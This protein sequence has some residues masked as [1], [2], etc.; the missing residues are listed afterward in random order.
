MVRGFTS[1]ALVSLAAGLSGTAARADVEAPV[2]SVPAASRPALGPADN[3]PDGS[4]FRPELPRGTPAEQTLRDP[5]APITTLSS[6]IERAYWANPQLLAERARARSLDYRIPQARGQYGPQIEYSAS[7]GYQRN[8]Y[9]QPIGPWISRS[10]WTSAAS[11]VLRQPLFTFGRLRASE[12]GARAT[13]AFGQASLR[14]TEQQTMFAAINAYALLM[15]DRIGVRI[16]SDNVELLATHARDTQTRLDA[17]ESTA[18]DVQQVVARLELAR[19]QLLA[20]QSTAAA[21]EASFL[22]Y[23]GAPAG[24]L[25]PP[26]PLL[27]PV[28]TLDDAY[29]YAVDHNPVLVAAHARERLSRAQLAG[30]RADLL[31]RVDLTGSASYGSSSPFADGLHTTELRAGVTISGAIDSGTRSARIGEAEE[32]NDADWR[33]I[34][35]TLRENREEIAAAWNEW[36]AQQASITRLAAGVEAAQ[37]AFDGGLLQERAGMRTTLDILE[38]ARDLLQVRSSYNAASAAAYAAQARLLVAIGALD[39]VSLLP[40]APA[41]NAAAHVRKVFWQAD[42]PLLAPL[43]GALD[44]ATTGSRPLRPVRDPAAPLAIGAAALKP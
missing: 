27:I 24:D 11:A 6:A 34:D 10:G 8:N 35:E 31:P 5:A 2:L 33:L 7:Y 16:A 13:A 17:R 42:F 3:A 21:S 26:N 1:T 4:G 30:A 18:T 37:S 39:H 20:A 14:T 23:V 40:D 25:G 15:R 29:V 32:A 44:S 36:Q 28:R 38:L 41:Y 22:R 43:V 12:D 19:A 9:E